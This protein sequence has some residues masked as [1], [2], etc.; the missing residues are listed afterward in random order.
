MSWDMVRM[1]RYPS[2][3][4]LVRPRALLQKPSMALSPAS[5]VPHLPQVRM[6]RAIMATSRVTAFSA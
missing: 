5:R 4:I 2:T 3:S 1:R 6:Q